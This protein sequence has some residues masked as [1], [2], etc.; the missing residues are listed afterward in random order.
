[1][2]LLASPGARLLVYAFP[3][4]CAIVGGYLYRR[5]LPGYVGFACWLFF[6][7]PFVRRLVDF[8]AGWIPATAVL[9]APVLTLCAPALWLV[10]EWR[11]I[12][13]RRAA[14]LVCALALCAY[15]SLIGLFHFP[16]A[17]V[18]QD[19]VLWTSPLVFALV[20]LLNGDRVAELATAFETAFVYG[21]LVVGI[22]G[23]YQFFFLPAWDVLWIEQM[24]LVSI[25]LPE[26]T[27]ARVFST[28]NSPQVMASFLVA[29]ILLAYNSRHRLRYV[30]IP[31][32]LL[33][34]VLSQAR[35]GW[36]AMLAGSVY[37]LIKLPVKQKMH[38]VVGLFLSSMAL[39]IAVQ[40]PDLNDVVSKRF[41][42]LFDGKNDGSY[43]DRVD[44]YKGVLLGFQDDPYGLGMGATPAVAQGMNAF[45]HGGVSLILGDS[46][47]LMVLTTL[48]TAGTLILLGLLAFL[49]RSSFAR[50]REI[51]P[52]LLGLRAVLIAVAA[53][54]L[55][56]G[57]IAAPTGFITW[58]AL[59]FCLAFQPAGERRDSRVATTPRRPGPYCGKLGG[60]SIQ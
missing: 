20:V 6:L 49:A 53:E 12:L 55:L 13:R 36:I 15:A 45:A 58:A 40:N 50:R 42:T 21:L 60:E 34:L 31:V 19:L 11:V 28:M 37:L 43:M 17:L 1:M 27:K 39:L 54:A 16:L 56:D 4:C 30:A 7:T 18:V 48:G 35:S 33:S 32:G 14:P 23:I 47:L 25:G 52:Q 44:G 9:L 38:L 41:S 5:N 8:R 59:A 2:A 51:S 10:P 57:V 26:P 22:Y 3:F 29:G 46:T 24:K